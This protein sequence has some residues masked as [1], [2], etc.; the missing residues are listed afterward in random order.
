[1][2]AQ[3]TQTPWKYDGDGFDSL[4][5]QDFGTDGYTVMD[6]ECTP[7]CEMIDMGDDEEAE[8]NAA[9][10]VEACNNYERLKKENAELT[11]ALKEYIEQGNERAIK[12]LRKEL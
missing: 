6:D 12:T 5:A 1:M 7:I 11:L 2:T 3:H 4:A 10:I 9:F 8:A